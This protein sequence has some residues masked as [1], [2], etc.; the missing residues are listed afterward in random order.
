M[1][2]SD[3]DYKKIV[4]QL[5]AVEDLL[6]TIPISHPGYSEIVLHRRTSA[7]LEREPKDFGMSYLIGKTPTFH[8]LATQFDKD[9]E[10]ELIDRIHVLIGLIGEHYYAKMAGPAIVKEVTFPRGLAQAVGGLLHNFSEVLQ[11]VEPEIDATITVQQSGTRATLVITMKDGVEL[12]RV[13]NVLEAY[14]RFLAGD[15]S[16]ASELAR[17]EIDVMKIE[18]SRDMALHQ[19]QVLERIIAMQDKHAIKSEERSRREIESL[20]DINRL[21]GHQLSKA[22]ETIDIVIV[23]MLS[24][25]ASNRLSD[26]SVVADLVDLLKSGGAN[27]EAIQ[28]QARRIHEA[29]PGLAKRIHQE[30]SDIALSGVVGN[31][32]FQTLLA[33]LRML[34]G[35]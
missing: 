24:V 11:G 7:F 14:S 33:S 9:T 15:E 31:A 32:T 13:E 8:W 6:D 16:M 17:T 27:D 12:D 5:K 23:Q 25:V 26:N 4:A 30:L 19:A 28:E 18:T 2:I 3:D 35:G 29:D 34:A 1:R 20:R 10:Y 21:L 22:S